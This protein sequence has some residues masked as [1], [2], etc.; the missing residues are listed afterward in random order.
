MP[1]PTIA[2]IGAT[3]AVGRECLAI[4]EQRQFPYAGIKLLA[5]ARSAGATI[6]FNDQGHTVADLAPRSCDGVKLA[7][8]AAGSDT[9]KTFAPIA[10]KAGATVIAKSAAHR[11][12][13]AC[14][15]V[16][17]EINPE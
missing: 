16:I 14:P 12:D 5:S 7:F 9:A 1:Q 17:P 8:S 13:A 3:G 4:L 6:P 15:L 2:L 11:D 10:V